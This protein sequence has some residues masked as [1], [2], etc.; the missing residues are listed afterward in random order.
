MTVQRPTH[1]QMKEVVAELG[2]H[3]SDARVQE[4][5]DVMQGTLDAYD[6]VDSLPDYLPPVLYPRTSGY[7]PTAE[8]NPMKF[9]RPTVAFDEETGEFKS[10]PPLPQQVLQK[11]MN[12]LEKKIPEICFYNRFT[13]RSERND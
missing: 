3:M 10:A 4:F 6:V 13:T 8:E 1:A 5:L 11:S 7:R 2:M 9:H 12:I